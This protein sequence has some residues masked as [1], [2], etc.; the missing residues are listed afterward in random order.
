M[1][2]TGGDMTQPP[3]FR[4]SFGAM[5]LYT[6]LRFGLFFALFG[7]LWLVG[8][9]GFLGAII[10]LVLSV[11]LSFVLLAKPR[12]AFAQVLEQRFEARKARQAD[13]DAELQGNDE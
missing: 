4:R 2:K 13:L 7:L 10:A 1:A 9:K 8:V 3:M 12:Q 5:W 6:I 11:P